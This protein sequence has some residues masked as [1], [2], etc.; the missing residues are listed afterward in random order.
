MPINA[1]RRKKLSELLPEGVI[2]VPAWLIKN[3]FERSA[4]DNLVKSGA[5]TAI[6]HGVYVRGSAPLQWQAI[7]YSLQSILQ[8]DLVLGGLTSLEMQGFSHYLSFSEKKTIHLYGKTKMP[9]WLN[10]LLPG[11][12]FIWHPEKELLGRKKKLIP[13]QVKSLNSFVVRREWREGFND[14]QLSSQERAFLEVLADVP[15]KISFEHADQLIQGMTSLSPRSLQELLE[16][17]G[18]V[19]VKRLFFWLADRHNYV[20]LQKLDK[21][22]IDFG[23]G[24]RMLIKGGKL[25]TK[26]KISVPK[27]S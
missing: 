6:H 17:C 5:L 4:I 24:N 21:E 18:N 14:L 11:V 13:S 16:L 20:W 12:T 8:M 7:V 25:D 3:G 26:Y 19:K 15:E 22:R 10:T 1:T 23:K 2:T 27:L 9:A